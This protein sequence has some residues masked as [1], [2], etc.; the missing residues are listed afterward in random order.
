MQGPSPGRGPSCVETTVRTGPTVPSLVR[1]FIFTNIFEEPR[2]GTGQGRQ[3]GPYQSTGFRSDEEPTFRSGP[4]DHW[5]P[6]PDPQPDTGSLAE[7]ERTGGKKVVDRGV[8]HSK[9]FHL[10]QP[11]SL[12][13]IL[14][15]DV[16]H[17]HPRGVWLR[18]RLPGRGFPVDSCLP[19]QTHVERR[20]DVSRERVLLA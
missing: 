4:F 12:E 10:H 16:P 8:G 13:H 11:V 2:R 20:H 18:S 6:S 3:P 1:R 9:G 5:G 15:D 14:P 17:P 19:T 7:T